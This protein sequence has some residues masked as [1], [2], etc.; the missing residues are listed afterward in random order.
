[1]TQKKIAVV[2]FNLGGPTGPD[3][4]YPFLVNFFMDPNIIP[5][6]KPFRFF[7]SR[8]IALTRSKGPAR[9]AYGEMG[10]SS[11]LLENTLAQQNALH[12]YLKT[13]IDGDIRVYSCMRYWHPMADSVVP[14]VQA[15]KPDELVL[16]SLY[17][18][19]SSTTFW[20]SLNDWMDVAKKLGYKKEPTVICCYPQEKGFIKA[21]AELVREKIEK[22]YNTIG[23][24]PRVLFSAHSLPKKII[25]KGDPYEYQCN[26]T[27]Q[28]IVKELGMD[29]LDYR[30]SYQS[31]IGPQTWLGP[32]T[33]DEIV[34]AA[35]TD[36]PLIIYPHAFVSE[37][38]ET[39]VEL[40]IE[41]KHL[42]DEHNAPYY[43]VVP[44]VSTHPDFI[45]GLGGL[46]KTYLGQTGVFSDGI[47]GNESCPENFIWCCK[48]R[49]KKEDVVTST[50]CDHTS[51]CCK[52]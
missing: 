23:R 47:D 5:L 40:G 38:V 22:C 17:P 52:K 19:M 3:A 27:A 50:C 26:L 35:K 14:Q 21:S 41:Y 45:A 9:E 33:S 10:G 7:L 1:M 25:Q 28:A 16:L 20:S 24:K 43:D 15:F 29:D 4:I 6:P 46:V 11:P 51:S 48:Q 49:A 34:E 30:I 2:L 32:Q 42:A 13:Q 39:I 8:F 44:T 31:K 12:E 18:Q 36:T 37:H